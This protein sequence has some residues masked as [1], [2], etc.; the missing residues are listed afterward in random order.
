MNLNTL[1]PGD[2]LFYDT[3]GRI[4]HVALYIG[5]GKIVHAANENFGICIW[6]AFYRT[7]CC[8]VSFLP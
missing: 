8:A 1:R 2:L 7:P 6:D 5:N 3:N 4:N